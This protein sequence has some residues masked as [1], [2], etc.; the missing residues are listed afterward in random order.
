[1]DV[2]W[3]S[4]GLPLFDS[5]GVHMRSEMVSRKIPIGV[6]WDAYGIPLGFPSDSYGFL[7]NASKIRMGILFVRNL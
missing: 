6:L 3:G 1:M 7:L 4:Y 5:C 2:T